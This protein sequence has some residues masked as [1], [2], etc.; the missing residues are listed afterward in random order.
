MKLAGVLLLFALC[1]LVVIALVLI[2]HDNPEYADGEPIA[3]VQDW[4]R[5]NQ[6]TSSSMSLAAT[7]T[8]ETLGGIKPEPAD[9]DPGEVI[10]M[11][12]YLGD[13]KWLVSKAELDSTYNETELTFDEWIAKTKGWDANRFKEYKSDLSPED[14]EAF[15][16]EYRTY[17]P[18]QL[19]VDIVD[20]WYVY[21]H[22]GLVEEI[23]DE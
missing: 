14:R 17:N 2:T 18:E 23:Q 1:I 15:E 7:P 11:E 12:D 10:W 8:E 9:E 5:N 4:L 6:E 19:P 3:I 13:G 16:E 20:K 21:E 22:T